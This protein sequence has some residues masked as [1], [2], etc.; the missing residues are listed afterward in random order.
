MK[1]EF[2]ENG[3][4]ANINENENTSVCLRESSLMLKEGIKRSAPLL[5][6]IFALVISVTLLPFGL[7]MN[8]GTD[9]FAELLGQSLT[10]WI[11]VLLVISLI[12][13]AVSVICGTFAIVLAV[14]SKKPGTAGIVVALSVLSFVICAICLIL[15]ILG[16]FL[17]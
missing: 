1:V 2:H 6:A 17:W 13:I 9:L 8:I 4:H 11:T 16:F 15:N 12:M 10:H 5:L 3:F 14:K 7:F